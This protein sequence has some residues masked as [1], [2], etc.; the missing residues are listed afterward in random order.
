[1]TDPAT[2]RSPLA[3]TI[4]VPLKLLPGAKSRLAVGLDPAEHA[5]LVEAIRADT[6]AAAAG[7]GRILVVSDRATTDD[8]GWYGSYLLQR[9]PGLNAALREGAGAA[10]A[11]WP[12]DG[13]AA[14]VGDLPALRSAELRDA[15]LLAAGHPR[16]FVADASGTGTSLLT[17]RPGVGLDPQ[18]G[19]DSAARHARI[20]HLLPAG[21]GLRL[22]V[23]TA[24]DLAQAVDLGVG[25]ATRGVIGNGR[26]RGPGG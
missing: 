9:E 23:D 22:D 18:F 10:A 1:M 3:W 21:P 7:A 15:L 16:C 5:R 25:P 24:A 14:L 11:R 19:P 13:V 17:A 2:A 20:A 8:A 26:T 12:D 6:L 4:V